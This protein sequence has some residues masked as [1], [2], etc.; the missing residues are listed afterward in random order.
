MISNQILQNTLEGLK[1][2]SKVDL[3]AMDPDGKEI[4]STAD[5]SGCSKAAVQFAHSMVDSQ[6][7]KGYQYFKVFDEFVADAKTFKSKRILR[8]LQRERLGHICG[9]FK[10]MMN[11]NFN[12][13]TIIKPMQQELRRN[14]WI[15]LRHP[16][17]LPVSAFGVACAISFT[18]TKW[19]WQYM[20]QR[21]RGY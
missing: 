18:M 11:S 20:P 16:K 14:L 13:W 8:L 4:A 1:G 12:D 17:P 2:I 15:L 19:L 9:F 7:I 3:C 6:E 5:M 21:V 10:R